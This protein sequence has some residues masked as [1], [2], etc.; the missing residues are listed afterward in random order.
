MKLRM[1]NLLK[2]KKEFDE[3]NVRTFIWSIWNF[4]KQTC[5]EDAEIGA[6]YLFENFKHSDYTGVI[7]VSGSEKGAVY[8]TMGKQML[9]EVLS[10][11]FSDIYNQGLDD[12]KSEWMRKDYAGEMANIVA[13]NARNY[14]GEQFLISTPVVLDQP[15]SSVVLPERTTG[16]VL[17]VLWRK[18]TCHLI[19]SFEMAK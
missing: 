10:I 9:S 2:E 15:E 17:P 16:L 4:F 13:G 12:A 1:M 5:N 19:L 18:H 6:P 14:L 3:E 8:W 7:A 11:Q